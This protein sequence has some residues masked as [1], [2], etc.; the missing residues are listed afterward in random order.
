MDLVTLSTNGVSP[1]IMASCKLL[2][3]TSSMTVRAAS[4]FS[5]SRSNFVLCQSKSSRAVAVFLP[6]TFWAN[7][8]FSE[9]K[10]D[11]MSSSGTLRV[12]ER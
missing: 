6:K 11:R 2:R 10:I 4:D 12:A 1:P 5:F 9:S 7:P 3:V 8:S